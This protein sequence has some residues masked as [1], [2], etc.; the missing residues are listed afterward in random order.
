MIRELMYR[1]F[2][3][4]DRKSRF[5]LNSVLILYRSILPETSLFLIYGGL[6]NFQCRQTQAR[7]LILCLRI[8][9]LNRG[10]SGRNWRSGNHSSSSI[11]PS[12]LLIGPSGCPGFTILRRSMQAAD[13][14]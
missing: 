4:R 9:S 13:L 3:K 6:L 7:R 10:L 2:R 12:T 11:L 8:G 14:L 5:Q 1:C